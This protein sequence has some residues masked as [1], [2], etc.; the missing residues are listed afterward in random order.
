MGYDTSFHPVSIELVQERLIP[1]ILGEGA[2]DDLIDRALQVT[3]TRAR[4]KAWAL[5]AQRLA[6]A[7]RRLDAFLHVWGR[8][9]FI[10]VDDVDSALDVYEQFLWASPDETDALALEQLHALAPGLADSTRALLQPAP[11]PGE[12]ALRDELLW[13]LHIL[14]DAVAAV[15]QGRQQIEVNGR[16]HDPRDL[17]RRE[18]PF[19]VLSFASALAPGWMSRGATWPSHLVDEAPLPSRPFFSKPEALLGK[20]PRELPSQGWFL[21]PTIVE[22]YMVGG[23]VTPGY[24]PPLRKYLTEHQGALA[25]T[26]P[27]GELADVRRELRKVDEALALAQ[28]KKWAFCEATEIYSGMQGQL[29]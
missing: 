14:K 4:A 8:P 12:Q 9:F 7:P 25:S 5:A 26:R 15:R 16:A 19:A 29:N 22:N 24:V 18:V 27:V 11:E 6:P 17:L 21:Y 10:V 23:L 1:Y 28:R 3:R 20:L 2:I 13:R